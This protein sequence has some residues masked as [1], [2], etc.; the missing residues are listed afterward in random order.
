[1]TIRVLAFVIGLCVLAATAHVTIV[2]GGGGYGSPHAVLTLAIAAGTGIGAL[3]IGIAWSQRRRT[4]AVALALALL[5]GEL[6]GLAMTAER[7]VAQRE[8]AQAPARQAAS[9]RA[10]LKT[11][12]AALTTRLGGLT[13]TP[14]LDAALARQRR[15]S[16]T[17]GAKAAE[18]GCA[19]NCRSLLEAETQAAAAEVAA[20]RGELAQQRRVVETAIEALRARAYLPATQ[21]GTPLADRLGLPAWLLDL[22]VAALG[23]LGANG[24]AA[25]LVA[26]AAHRPASVRRNDPAPL[27]DA[28][29]ATITAVD[30]TPLPLRAE[31]PPAAD[32]VTTMLA[33]RPRRQRATP[34]AAVDQSSDGS[35]TASTVVASAGRAPVTNITQHAA[36]FGLER[37]A[38]APEGRAS[39]KSIHAAY[40]AWCAEIG[41]EELPAPR[42]AEALAKLFSGVGIVIELVDGEPVARGIAIKPQQAI[43]ATSAAA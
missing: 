12:I 41:S 19:Q 38:P 14:R 15:A 32:P 16:E 1:M 11:E 27:I 18:K 29:A 23:S 10:V 2:A 35:E 26:F 3:V 13:S 31:A 28:S 21:S 9:E 24:L 20:A 40:R 7:L 42:I 34:R 30:A 22:I 17:V 43:A 36:R 39:L 4:L 5:S 37:L 6:F 8:A 33:P 25:T